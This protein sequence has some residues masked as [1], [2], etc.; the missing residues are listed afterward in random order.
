MKNKA[1]HS[2]KKPVVRG[3]SVTAVLGRSKNNNN[4]N[5]NLTTK[6]MTRSK[7]KRKLLISLRSNFSLWHF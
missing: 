1:K 6:P 4:S 2:L 3:Y 7:K 5:P